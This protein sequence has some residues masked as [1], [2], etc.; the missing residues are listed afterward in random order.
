M[1]GFSKIKRL[2]DINCLRSPRH[3]INLLQYGIVAFGYNERAKQLE[4]DYNFPLMVE[5]PKGLFIEFHPFRSQD[6]PFQVGYSEWEDG[7]RYAA[8]FIY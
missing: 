7:P 8:K 1:G 4:I 2:H 3:T 6:Y 5:L